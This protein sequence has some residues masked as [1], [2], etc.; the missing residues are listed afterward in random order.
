MAMHPFFNPLIFT[1]ELIYTLLAVVFCFVIYY[2]TKDLYDLT[3]H[4]GIQHFRNAFLFFGLAYIS[5]FALQIL[6][7]SNITMNLFMRMRL[8]HPFFLLF[9]SYLS[10]MAIFYLVYSTIWKK[11]GNNHFIILS[12]ALAILLSAITFICR[13]PE[14]MAVFQFVLLI[15]ALLIS[16]FAPEKSRRFSKNKILYFLVLVFWLF[17]IFIITPG[18]LIPFEIKA[19]LYLLS[20]IAFFIIYHRVFKWIK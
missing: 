6:M 19:V 5:R 11:I 16:I 10:T 1:T 17:N 20:L 8:V 14:I 9:T 7:L 13:S 4:K 3:K 12:N 2:K 15:I 18:R